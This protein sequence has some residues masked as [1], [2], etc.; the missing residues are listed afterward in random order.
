MTLGRLLAAINDR[1]PG[2][3][4]AWW[5]TDGRRAYWSELLTRRGV[6]ALCSGLCSSFG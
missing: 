1:D 4:W 6:R 5:N 2:T 3:W